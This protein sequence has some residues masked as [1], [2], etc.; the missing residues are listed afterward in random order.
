MSFRFF[1]MV[2]SWWWGLV[3]L[4]FSFFRYF[5]LGFVL[6]W[7]GDVFVISVFRYFGEGFVGVL[8][9]LC[10]GVHIVAVLFGVGWWVLY[11]CGAV[12]LMAN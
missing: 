5:G 12:V 2:V 6:S 3:L 4:L 10:R 9:F 1:E 11:L 8:K 7:W